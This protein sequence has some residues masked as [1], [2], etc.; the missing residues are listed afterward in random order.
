MSKG[1]AALPHSC[2]HR[3]NVYTT[4]APLLT[5]GVPG[6]MMV[7]LVSDSSEGWQDEAPVLE[8]RQDGRPKSLYSLL[9]LCLVTFQLTSLLIFCC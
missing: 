8:P 9:E 3:L 2:S 1:R 7:V 5:L 4:G 6:V